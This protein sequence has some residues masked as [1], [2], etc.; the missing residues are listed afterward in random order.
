MRVIRISLFV[1]ALVFLT[2]AMTGIELGTTYNLLLM[3]LILTTLIIFM[4]SR[5]YALGIDEAG[6]QREE[7]AE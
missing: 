5:Y 4:N 7:G 1:T 6:L 2:W 3:I